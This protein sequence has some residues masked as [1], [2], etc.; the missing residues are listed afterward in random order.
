M[1]R[2]IGVDLGQRIQNLAGNRRRRQRNAERDASGSGCP[3]QLIVHRAVHPLD[4]IGQSLAQFPH[5]GIV[6]QRPA[7]HRQRRFQAM[8]QIAQRI[9]VALEMGVALAEQRI[10]VGGQRL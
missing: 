2:P 3:L 7:Q 10:Q 1:Q 9:S 6:L 4:L 8:R 5:I